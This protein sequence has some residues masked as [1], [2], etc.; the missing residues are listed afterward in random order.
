MDSKKVP[1]LIVLAALVLTTFSVLTPLTHYSYNCGMGYSR[2][3]VYLGPFMIGSVEVRVREVQSPSAVSLSRIN[4]SPIRLLQKPLPVAGIRCLVNKTIEEPLPGAPED[5]VGVGLIVRTP[6]G[7]RST[8]LCTAAQ[9]EYVSRR[10][11]GDLG[12]TYECTSTR[13][14]QAIL[15]LKSGN[16]SVL[17]TM[18]DFLPAL[19]M[20]VREKGTSFLQVD[21]IGVYTLSDTL[22]FN[23]G[24]RYIEVKYYGTLDLINSCPPRIIVNGTE[25]PLNCG[26]AKVGE[27]EGLHVVQIPGVYLPL[28][29]LREIQLSIEL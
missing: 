16:V 7:S 28:I 21:V 24:G 9:S 25:I 4:N 3:D 22:V 19:S 27:I 10:I 5:T 20:M 14:W 6:Q 29:G 11:S 17:F 13:I 26:I 12:E 8:L 1:L 18:E 2:A 15:P 23:E